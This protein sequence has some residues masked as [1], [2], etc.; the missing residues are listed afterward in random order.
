MKQVCAK[1]EEA[2][3]ADVDKLLKSN[4]YH[5]RSELVRDLLRRWRDS[6]ICKV[7]QR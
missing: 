5:T 6:K 3:V 2:L 4:G 7:S 1:V